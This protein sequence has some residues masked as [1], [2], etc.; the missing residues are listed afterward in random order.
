VS[1]EPA[2]AHASASSRNIVLIAWQRRS[3]VLLGLVAGFALALLFYAQKPPVYQSSAQVLVV[4]KQSNVLPVAGGDPRISFYEDYV[5]THLILLRSPL[6]V[7]RAVRKRELGNLQSLGADPVGTI[8]AGLSASRDDKKDATAA[9][10]NIINLTYRGG[11]PADCA[12]VLTAVIESYRDFL[13]ET[14]HNVS[15]TTLDLLAHERDMLDKDIREKDQK[16]SE[17]RKNAPLLW[18]GVDG[19]N[20]HIKR[21]KDYQ[22]EQTGLMARAA[23]LRERLKAVETARNQGS[24]FALLMKLA[25]PP[26]DKN[27]PLTPGLEKSLEEQ[28]FPLELKERTLLKDFGADHQEVMRVREQIAMTKEF[29]QKLDRVAR[30]GDAANAPAVS[31]PLETRLL[32]LRQE[33][34]LVETKSA[35]LQQLIAEEEKQAR[36]LEHY[37]IQDENFRK[38]I[39]RTSMLLEERITRLKALNLSRDSGGLEAKI[40]A[41]PAAGGKVSPLVWQILPAG[42]LLG[43]IGG[44]ALAYLLD[45]LD[46]SFRTPEEIRRRLGLPVVGHVPFLTEPAGRDERGRLDPLLVVHHNPTSSEAEAFRGVRTALYFSTRAER[47]KVI[48]ITSPQMGDGKSLLAANLAVAMAQSGRRVVLVD[49]D[50]RRGRLHRIFGLTSRTGLASVI[51]SAVELATAVQETEIPRLSVLPC[52]PRPTNPAEL[53]TDPRLEEVLE[54]LR[55]QYDFVLVDTPPLLAV[56]DSSSVVPRVDGVLFVLRPGKNGRPPAERARDLLAESHALVFGVVVNGVAK[57]GS[58]GYGYEHYVAGYEYA[59]DYAEAHP[60]PAE[61][62][63]AAPPAESL[64][65]LNNGHSPEPALPFPPKPR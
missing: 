21:I 2:P 5:A 15:N 58:I 53:L 18:K 49:A 52:G 25:T 65:T 22:D 12:A 40:I 57:A 37:E 50:L 17:F 8:R 20:L 4:K 64:A 60:A 35:A 24:P 48:Q 46:R 43:L 11:D 51:G 42:A 1:A 55:G 10:N 63:E 23:D 16:Y 36:A 44:L 56:S 61:E 41:A 31:D 45:V 27:Q 30:K 47:H 26:Q 38:E 6:I 14:Y 29:F 54:E 62:T 28:L 59:A 33:L 9:P 19:A 13:D 7:E 32:A 34:A 3:L 39:A